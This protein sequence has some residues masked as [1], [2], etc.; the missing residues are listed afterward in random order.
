MLLIPAIDRPIRSLYADVAKQQPEITNLSCSAIESIASEKFIALLRRIAAFA[1]DST[2]EDDI[3]LVR[4]VYDLHLIKE[5]VIKNHRIRELVHKVI[6]IDLD[7]FGRSNTEFKNN[8]IEELKFGLKMLTELPLYRKRYDE[9]IGP[10]VYH[11]TPAN[12]D[13][14]INTIAQLADMWLV[15]NK[16]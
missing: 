15:K 3:T 14:A 9:F 13:T 6:H 12:W 7:Q 1:R 10:L 5:L 16:G 4:H 11:P 2:K 8:P